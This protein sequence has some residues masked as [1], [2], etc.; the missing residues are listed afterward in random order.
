MAKGPQG[1]H[2]VAPSLAVP[3]KIAGRVLDDARR[4]EIRLVE[5]PKGVLDVDA[6]T[7][8]GEM[9]LDPFKLCLFGAS[10]CTTSL[11]GYAQPVRQASTVLPSADITF[12]QNWLDAANNGAGVKYEKP[13]SVSFN[14]CMDGNTAE[15]DDNRRNDKY[16]AYALAVH[17]SGHAL[18]LSDWTLT[19]TAASVVIPAFNKIVGIINAIDSLPFIDLP[20]IQPITDISKELVYQTSHPRTPGSVMNYDRKTGVLNL[21]EPDCSPYPL[22]VMAIYAL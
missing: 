18:G 11:V 5:L 3:G 19:G 12:N 13:D 21:S 22:D 8:M 10:A 2:P 16:Y 4:S 17:E 6:I 9:L 1:L 15:P 7:G 14:T 20:D